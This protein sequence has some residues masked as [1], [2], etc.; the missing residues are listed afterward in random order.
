[1]ITLPTV[2]LLAAL[3]SPGQPVLLD[4]HADWCGPCRSMEPT[5]YRLVSEGYAVRKINIDRDRQVARQYRVDRV[6]TY[7]MVLGGREVARI[8]GPTSYASLTNM[9]TAAKPAAPQVAAS[10]SQP[11]P[12]AAAQRLGSPSTPDPKTRAMHAT[13]RLRVEDHDGHSLGTGTIIDTHGQEALIVTC[14]HIFRSS[15][16]KGKIFVDL[17]APGAKTPVQGHLIAHDLKHDVALVAIRPGIQL[18]PVPVAAAGYQVRQGDRVF[19]IGCD[20]GAPASLRD[21]HVTAINKYTGPSNIEVAG[22]PVIGRSG[23][24]L[25]SAEGH[26]IGVCNLADP[27]DNEGIYA[28]LSLVHQHLDQNNLAAVYRRNGP[29]QPAA[30]LAVASRDTTP[31]APQPPA[32]AKQMPRAPVSEGSTAPVPAAATAGVPAQFASLLSAST[33]DTEIICIV[34]SKSDPRGK[35]EVFFLDRPS[36][37]LLDHLT[38]ESRLGRDGHPVLLQATRAGSSQPPRRDG[39]GLSPVMRAQSGR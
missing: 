33:D 10:Q 24:G 38:S 9:F 5:V 15:G 12:A 16:G 39:Q 29:Q 28:A 32:M 35:S 3:A 2:V 27:K 23:G 36:R 14:G 25:F 37:T 18:A 20:Q 22:Q 11:A 4:F 19:S 1:M 31:A 30:P 21:S 26:L 34:R 7:V 17:F 6:P 8:V 13:V